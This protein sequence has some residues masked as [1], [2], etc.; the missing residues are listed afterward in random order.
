MRNWKIFVIF[1]CL[2]MFVLNYQSVDAQE[3]LTQQV[4][5]IF[6]QSCL[7]CHGPSGSFKEA[8]LLDRNALIDTQV[9][10]PG[11]PENSE[12]Y[13]RLLGPTEKGP[14][15]PLNLPPL[16]PEA[17]E[18]IA[19]W[20]TAGAPDWDV[21]HDINF[22]TTDTILDTIR[23]HLKS[24]DPFDRPSARY[25]TMTHLYNAG[26]SPE[27]LSDYRIALSKLVNS[28]SW[29][30][31]I[32]NPTPVDEAQTIFYIDLRR[33][34]WNNIT[35]DVW[36]QIE[37]AY[38][39][40]I[41]FDPETQTG[42]LEKLTHLQTET[43]S[44]VPFVHVD[45]FLA[46]A[47]LPPLYHDILGLPQTDRVL[48]AQLEVNVASNIRNAPGINVW[49]AGFNDS[50]VSSNNRVVERHTS[51]YGAYW[52]SYDF[53]GSVGSQ[54]IFTHPLD[55]TH[56]GGEIIFNLPNGLQ[57]YLLVDANGVRL[58]DAPIKIVSNPAASDPTVRNGLSCIGCHT[59]GMKKFE[60]SVR[61]A[62]EQDQNPPYNKEHALRLYPEQ[63]VLDA[64]V[65][66]DTVRFRQ[67]LEKI[68]GPFVDD[69]SRQRFFKQHENEPIQRFHELFQMPLD[70]SHAAAAV[71]LETAEFLTHIREKQSLK[72]LGLQTL[73][74]VNGTVK[75]DAWTSNFDDVISALNTPDSTLPP[76]VQRPEL[77]PGE[78]VDIPDPNL[79]AAIEAVLNKA[80]RDTI[81]ASEM[82]TLERLELNNMDISDLTGLEFAIN[83]NWLNLSD[84]NIS[85]LSPIAS[86]IK[87]S[88]L[89]FT[90]NPVSDLSPLKG[91]KNLTGLWFTNNRQVSDISPLTG[92]INL[93]KLHFSSTLISDLSPLKGLTN[94]TALEY[95]WMHVPDLSILVGLVNLEWFRSWGTGISDLSPLVGLTKL[96]DLDICGGHISDLT[97]LASLTGLKSLNMYD[98]EI[99]DLSP[100]ANLTGLTHLWMRT[101]NISDIS[102]LA[103]LTHLKSLFLK[104]NE[105]SDISPLA[106][107]TNLRRLG[108]QDNPISDFSPLDELFKNPEVQILTTEVNFTDPNLRA[109]IEAELGKAAGD[110]ITAV[111]MT[112][113]NRLVAR[114]RGIKDLTGLQLAI[115]L[116]Q[117]SLSGNQISDLSPIM[118][119]T[120][121]KKLWLNGNPVSDLSPLKR[122]TN[123]TILQFDNTHVSDLSPL[124]GL[125]NLDELGAST[126]LISDLS[127]LKGLKN[128]R[129][130]WFHRTQVSDLSP[131]A[132]LTHLEDIAVNQGGIFDAIRK[133]EAQTGIVIDTEHGNIS[134]LSPLAGLINLRRVWF[135]GNPITD[136]SPL[137][138]LTKLEKVDICGG[139]IS[140]LKPLVGLT[141]LTGLFLA[142]NGI[143]DISPL[144]K[145]TDLKNLDLRSNNISDISPLAGLTHLNYLRLN[146]NNISDFSPLDAIRQHITLI[147]HDNP[148][149]PKGGP[150]IEGPWLWVVLPDAD[151]ESGTD[152]LAEASDGR[153]TESKIATHGATGGAPVG[154]HIWTSHKLP[155]NG[156]VEDM[157]EPPIPN[158]IIYGC[159]SLYSLHQQE[160]TLGVGSRH[161]LKV[162]FN[163]DLI[164]EQGHFDRN[165]R[166]YND[167]YPV[168]L[169]PGRN[170]LLVAFHSKADG[171]FGFE[172]GTEYTVS[173]A[174]IGYGLPDTP[175]HIGD[176]F[177]V[178]LNAENVSDL[179]GWQFDIS[180]DAT[181]LEVV[182]VNEGDF[183]KTESSTTFFQE[184]TIDNATGKITGLS[185][186]RLSEGGATGTGTLLSVTFA[187][188]TMG[189]A[190]LVLHNFELGS[191]TGE[192][193]AAESYEVVITIEGQL[194]IGD[195]NRDGRVS[196]LDLVLV[197]QHF[198]KTV[199]AN[200]EV[201]MN[202]D[203]IINV[204]D[205]ILVS[206]NM[207]KSTASASP[208][209]F[210]MDDIDGLDPAMIQ[211]WIK[212][213]Q[214][215]DDGSIVFQQGIANLQRL[216][217]SLIP[218]KTA[219][220]ANY[221]NPFNPETW[222]PYQ[223]ANPSDVRIIIYDP[224]GAVVRRLELGHQRA[225]H[226]TSRNRAAYW[227]GRNTVGERVA[228]GVYYYQLRADNL[229]LLRKMLIL[230]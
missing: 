104:E 156:R 65:V 72:N 142:A 3:N 60:D 80:P 66:K 48:E 160:T 102:P 184:G 41:A 73:I 29:K 86:L 84:N 13:K 25:F 94:L 118:G 35:T 227:D 99:S 210:A 141:N 47:S 55:F 88:E 148:G 172:T 161:E 31:E 96:V 75:R 165:A 85:D 115:N 92:L 71:G 140:D 17:I 46:T 150:K 222:I 230:K 122:L 89:R 45:W 228:S 49:R 169:Q 197:A 211:A 199:P 83:L 131:L 185:S 43:G 106:G 93:E 103:E 8:L 56:D 22:I 40:N 147:W 167:F 214:V 177:T 139:T 97:P 212:K 153:V 23:N 195:V 57:A 178:E 54:N 68:G 149:F 5:A 67:A 44:T 6:Q 193:I 143:S 202:G 162:W 2:L 173:D 144:A 154:N 112:K 159:V 24:L 208:S 105:I 224:R 203:G 158:G 182:E 20:I 70:D 204:L 64:L 136:L 189:E 135:W 128:L 38:P 58:D 166:D 78:S 226:Y 12:F 32:T 155:E 126:P 215:E 63:A 107:L 217:A 26:E 132:G 27:T 28:L 11:N 116:N 14:Q 113:L 76:V 152:L 59:Q 120:E 117:L 200:S 51:R 30:F 62:I 10:I 121:L 82:A 137:A 52:K 175:I 187:A 191:I 18:T 179:A 101:N 123:L 74:D 50:G 33:Y 98:H 129:I 69:A 39:Y 223:L 192:H 201:D 100:L 110:T 125:I 209:I 174:G 109:A 91:L 134:D 146:N 9:V 163:G 130:L 196:I 225:A 229:F 164:H 53:A 21:Q 181:V 90:N 34:E 190:R 194:T 95:N 171:F 15:M 4:S 36:T 61:T 77:I 124:A 198:G 133:I 37:Q 188:K 207:G 79:R 114:D 16:S 221:P 216:L 151:L 213:A 138:G 19:R 180:F 168:T 183:L 220:L 127:S 218:E 7:N 157:L 186:A 219:L 145:L 206:Q 176:T 119:L 108:L 205:L 87:L 111:E 81:T 170:V 1:V 42:L